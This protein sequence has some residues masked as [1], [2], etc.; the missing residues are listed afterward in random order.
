MR[1]LTFWILVTLRAVSMDWKGYGPAENSLE[2]VNDVHASY[3][4]YLFYQ[5]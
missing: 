3:R 4:T 5:Q 1:Q 2:N